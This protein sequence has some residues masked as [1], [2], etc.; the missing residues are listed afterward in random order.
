MMYEDQFD[1]QPDRPIRPLRAEIANTPASDGDDL[2][3]KIESLD[4]GH[5]KW[6]PCLG[7]QSRLKF[8]GTA[9]HPYEGADAIVQFDEE[10]DLWML[11]WWPYA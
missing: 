4:D 1:K 2:Y 11:E 6:G 8:D 7:W 10:H 9:Q 5:H 3:V